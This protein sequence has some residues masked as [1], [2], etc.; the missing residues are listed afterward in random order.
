MV[1]G[2]VCK[3]QACDIFGKN[4]TYSTAEIS[5]DIFYY[6]FGYEDYDANELDDVQVVV[7]LLKIWGIYKKGST[8]SSI[9]RNHNLTVEQYTKLYSREWLNLTIIIGDDEE[10]SWDFGA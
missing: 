2:H 8:I 5:E 1:R 3:F 7:S 10:I 9:R 6:I 4:K